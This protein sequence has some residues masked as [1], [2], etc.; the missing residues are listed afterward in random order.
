MDCFQVLI[1][2]RTLYSS[3]IIAAPLGQMIFLLVVGCV[4][5]RA[6]SRAFFFN[7][8]GR[9]NCGVVDGEK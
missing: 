1:M 3:G 9:T 2:L 8:A 5:D 6:F 4:C 7:D